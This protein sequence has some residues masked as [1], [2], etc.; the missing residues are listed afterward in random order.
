MQ[1]LRQSQFF[2]SSG[3]LAGADGRA[4]NSLALIGGLV[5]MRASRADLEDR[6]FLA[7]TADRIGTVETLHRLA[8]ASSTGTVELETYLREIFEKLS[9]DLA[10]PATSYAIHGVSM[11]PVPF[12]VALCVGLIA[13]ELFTNSLKYA[14]PAGL[15]AKVEV[16]C[17]CDESAGLTIVYE[18][19]GVG[20]PETFDCT[21]DGRAGLQLIRRLSRQL[22]SIPK[23]TSDSLGMRFEIAVP[24]QN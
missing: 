9:R 19:D 21:F 2:Q 15:P 23:W 14:H 6:V 16:S 13:A 24:N 10:Q 8:S 11:Q 7:E 1:A 3:Y 17:S 20:F 5:R 18:D 22:K 12:D 4:A